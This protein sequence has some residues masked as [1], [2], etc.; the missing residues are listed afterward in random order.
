MGVLVPSDK[1]DD[2]LPLSAFGYEAL[3]KSS[4]HTLVI[5]MQAPPEITTEG[6]TLSGLDTLE[7]EVGRF[8]VDS[9]LRTQLASN[10]EWVNVQPL[11][12][13]PDVPKILLR[14][15]SA[16]KYV[17]RKDSNTLRVLPVYVRF[18]DP[19][20]QSK[21]LAPF[22]VEKLR[23]LGIENNTFFLI[24]ANIARTSSA[25]KLIGVDAVLLKAIRELDVESIL[26]LKRE[27][28]IMEDLS[29]LVLGLLTL[30]QLGTDH[31]DILA[32]AH[33]GQMLLTKDK[34]I[35][36]SFCSAGFASQPPL[37]QKVR[38]VQQEQMRGIFDELLRS[39]LLTLAR[40]TMVSALDPTAAKPPAV[41]TPQAAKKWPVYVAIFDE[42]GTLAGQA[43]SHV[44][45]GP[46]EESVR[47]FTFQATKRA[48]PTLSKSNAS[49]YVIEISIPYGFS[50]VNKP[51]D[52]IPLL[53]GVVVEQ[54]LKTQALPPEAWRATPDPHQLLSLISTQ[55][56]S[57][58]WAYATHL[59]KLDSFRVLSFNE[60]E[61]FVDLGGG[62]KKKKKKS[63]DPLEED[64][65][66]GGGGSGAG[67]GLFSF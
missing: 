66:G 31:A 45:L 15:L 57:E 29:T 8:I 20:S 19:N 3:G 62:K 16:I 13:Y 37:S 11:L 28:V 30:K 14:H 26:N 47:K 21:D 33:S 51:D 65:D 44:A 56:G 38:H 61:P 53:N 43:G 40:Q 58:P 67:G 23:D 18:S 6:L 36:Q 27:E 50:K 22:V 35:P 17:L 1:R 55:L 7:T 63:T 4:Y 59:S 41:N 48:E 25:E 39:D 12:F 5:V 10:S 46:L 24:T 42:K 52:Y 49:S 2:I 32:Y 64:L 34:K 9:A 60:K 54:R